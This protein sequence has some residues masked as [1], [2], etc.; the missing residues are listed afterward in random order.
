MAAGVTI[1]NITPAAAEP[2]TS[3]LI[4]RWSFDHDH[5]GQVVD[6]S[7]NGYHG[8][9]IGHPTYVPGKVGKALRLDGAGDAVEVPA[10]L[11][12]GMAAITFA[13]WFRMDQPWP[14]GR[15]IAGF[16]GGT[17]ALYM[18]AKGQNLT[19]VVSLRDG[20]ARADAR[21]FG[22]IEA[23]EW[24]HLAVTAADG[25]VRCYLDGR[26]AARQDG[27]TFDPAHLSGGTGYLGAAPDTSANPPKPRGVLP[28]ALDDVRIYDVALD[29]E[30][31]QGLSGPP[32]APPGRNTPRYRPAR[33]TA[34]ETWR[35][36][37]R[38][39]GSC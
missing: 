24:H 27:V 10:E 18:E 5:D 6:D 34:P 33:D 30:Q 28:G 8:T 17:G 13:A 36:S 15:F 12:K 37:T 21:T 29:A 35:G 7:E 16:A 39:I 22:R 11:T 9:L 32:P 25:Q 20:G 1:G 19:P 31:I 26:E 38:W 23:G 14:W 2:P 3:H 4:A